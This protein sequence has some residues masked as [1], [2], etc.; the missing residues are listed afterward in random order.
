MYEISVRQHFDAAH[1]LRGYQGK[2]E[3][4]HGHRFQVVANVRAKQID[5]VGM[6]Y[7]FS[8]LKK[9]LGEIVSRFDHTCIND[10]PPFDRIN[11]SSENIASTIYNELQA[12]L[13]ATNASVYSI[14]VWE[15]PD[16]AVT[17]FPEEG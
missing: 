11:A 15:S 2:C 8:Q 3:N 16:S 5:E 7:D 17:Y 14:Q 12:M 6:A 9:Q 4:V 13:K 10:V 1:Y